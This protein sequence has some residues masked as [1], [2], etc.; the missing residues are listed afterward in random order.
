MTNAVTAI[1]VV[2]NDVLRSIR[3][4]EWTAEQIKFRADF[5][6]WNPVVTLNAK[7]Y[8]KA[9]PG[10]VFPTSLDGGIPTRSVFSTHI[11][12]VKV[13]VIVTASMWKTAITALKAKGVL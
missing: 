1:K 12:W 2:V 8:R 9:L 4:E 7:D 3:V 10:G 13:T 5:L 6:I 11:L